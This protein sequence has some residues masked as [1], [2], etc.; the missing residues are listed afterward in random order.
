MIKQPSRL[1]DGKPEVAL[2][3]V[4]SCAPSQKTTNPTLRFSAKMGD[5]EPEVDLTLI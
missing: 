2:A 5:G 3:L 1:T 4:R